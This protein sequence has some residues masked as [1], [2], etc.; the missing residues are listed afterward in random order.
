[1]SGITTFQSGNPI[2]LKFV[3]D[4]SAGSVGLAYFGTDAFNTGGNNAG[5]V[6]VVYTR[7]PRLSEGIGVGDRIV[8][9][10]ALSIP[11][12]GV[13]GPHQPPFY[14]RTPSRSN[15]D[16]SFFKNFNFNE[17]RRIQF[18]AG[19]FNVFNQAYPTR[20]NVE[21]ANSSDI[22]LTLNTTC[23]RRVS[24]IPNGIGGTRDNI[25]DPTGGYSFT[26]ETRENFGRITTKRGRRIVEFAF[27]FYF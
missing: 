20:V 24:G 12:F 23:N 3:G 26:Q 19:F 10:G 22:Y 7:D 4:I 11:A 27:K 5:P 14:I 15:F 8:D 6:G 1:M 17:S 25:C 13:S 21:N 2:R 18:R 16:V 9:I